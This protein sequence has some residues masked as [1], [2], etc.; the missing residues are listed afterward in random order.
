MALGDRVYV[1]IYLCSHN[2]DVA[3]TAVLRN[4]R[5]IR[6]AKDGFVP[7]RD[8]LGSNVE[9]VDV[10]TGARR[11]VHQA[12]DSIQ[13]PNW[14]PD[15]KR[16]L[17]NRNGRMYSFDLAGR[18]ISDL[19]TGSMTRNNN[20]HAL[21][22]DGT[23]LGLSGG[24]PSVIYT[25][26]V[27]GG[28][29]KQITPAGPSYL[30]GWSPDGRF[31]AFTGQRNGDFDIYLVPSGGGPE[32]RLTTAAGLDDGP[33][34]TPDG[35]WIYFNSARTG[36]M[37]V[38]RM[39]PDGSHQEQLTFD[40]FNNWFPHV[41]PDGRTIVFITYGPE[42]RADDHP[43]YKRVYIRKM[44]RDGRPPSVVAYVYGGQGSMNVNSWAPDSKAIAFVS[45]SGGGPSRTITKAALED[46]IRGGWAGQMI[47]VSYGAPTE[48][49]WNGRIIDGEITWSPE[50]VSN[51]LGQD[52]LYVEMTLAETMDRLGFDA[53]AEAVRR[54][55][56]GQRVRSV[57]R[58]RRRAPPAQPRHHGADVRPP[59][60]QHSRQRHRLPD[61][62]RLHRPDEPGPAAGV[63]QVL[64]ACRPRHELRRWPVRRHVHQRD[65]RR[66]VLRDRRAPRR[67]AR[68]GLP[69]APRAATRGSF[70]TCSS[71]RRRTPA[72]GRRTW[73]RIAEKWDRDDSCPDGALRP[74]NID[75]QLNGAYIALGLLYGRGDFARTLEIA[76]R[77]G[78]DSDCNPSTAGGILG[79]MLGY[80]G[81]PDGWKSGIPAVAGKKFAYT[82]SSLDDI[83]RTTL[84]RAL[85][86]VRLAGGTVT[87]D[88]VTIPIQSPV[89]AE[90]E[91][92][93]MGT[94]AARVGISDPAWTFKGFVKS[95]EAATGA[96]GAG[97]QASGAGAEAVLT[98]DGTA[99]SVIGGLRPAG[100]R[101][102]V[103]LDGKP[104]PPID[105]YAA[106]R[107]HDNALWHA[108]GLAQGPHTIRIVTRADADARSTGK[109]I[110]IL[111]AV[112]YRAR[113]R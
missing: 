9:L 100:G 99:V 59:A 46:R 86:L 52:D 56:Q 113:E 71:G 38:W 80:S 31:L 48:F 45:N 15:G 89:A 90:L 27:V 25:V 47:G 82:Q 43:W 19:D 87:D 95:V 33:E 36:R 35:R 93:D 37:Q 69:A 110:S 5:L 30:H 88:G 78:Q 16:L 55:L 28:T 18:T 26:P 57:A 74:F 105:A 67:R 70:A 101:A 73:Q 75:A 6:P 54:G 112:V 111:E 8:Y 40:D 1:G 68:A 3:E 58:Q 20:D 41:S 65:V 22:F 60:V 84:A 32:Q 81:I 23:M 63:Q 72:T 102:D 42:V 11:I 4:V 97:M 61:R 103:F 10:E 85:T 13:A 62:G 49:R 66:G 96:P 64:P 51:A 34:F 50:R 98:F 91:Q 12:D 79:V 2:P 39:R 106:A 94:P 53:T 104:A 14:T 76:T 17:M 44:P 7:Y 21:S 108:Y 24:Q 109:D 29:P 77:A 92:W 83:C 107:T